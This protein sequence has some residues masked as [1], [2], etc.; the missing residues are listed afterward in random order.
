MNSK[1]LIMVG[2]AVGSMLGGSVP[3]LWGGD[4]F[5]MWSVFLGGIGGLA[6]IWTG[7]RLSRL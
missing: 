6:G 5:S 4:L 2:L 1:F 3:M 7:Y